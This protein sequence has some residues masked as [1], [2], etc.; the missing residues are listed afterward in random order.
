MNIIALFPLPGEVLLLQ[1]DLS[2]LLHPNTKASHFYVLKSRG[3][4]PALVCLHGLPASLIP[5]PDSLTT[6]V[7]V[8]FQLKGPGVLVL[9][10]I[11]PICVSL[12]MLLS[13]LEYTSLH[14]NTASTLGSRS[15]IISSRKASLISQL[16]IIFLSGKLLEQHFTDFMLNVIFF[17]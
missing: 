10:L 15:E 14:P 17:M 2:Y 5:T 1:L 13:L 6:I 8:Q 3:L 9:V 12:L 4:N 11:L 7:L 16:E